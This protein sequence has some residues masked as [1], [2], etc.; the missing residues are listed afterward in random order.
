MTKICVF[1]D[2]HGKIEPMR[3]TLDMAAL[4]IAI[5]QKKP[6][7]GICRGIQIMTAALGGKLYQ[8]IHTQ[9][10]TP[11]IKHSQELDRSY[12]SHTIEVEKE[13]LLNRIF[14]S[15]GRLNVN[16]FHHQAVKTIGEGLAVMAYS[17]DGIIE[18]AYGTGSS[19]LRAYQWHP[20]RLAD[21]NEQ[22]R[23]LFEEFIKAC[24]G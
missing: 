17:E 19:F 8:D 18:A 21:K 14:G 9:H 7:L 2:S 6:I 1:S 16:S 20:E 10:S 15:A 4:R 13:S 22:N 24:N 5:D 23:L 3:D 11:C 12:P